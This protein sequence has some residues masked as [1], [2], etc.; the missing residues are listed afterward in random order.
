MSLWNLCTSPVV[1]LSPDCRIRRVIDPRR[2]CDFVVL[3][4]NDSVLSVS[5][6]L[7]C[8][9]RG[10]IL[11]F[12]RRSTFFSTCMDLHIDSEGGQL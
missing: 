3:V 10:P 2:E 1:D 9:L 8:C 11:V 5:P 6:T 4:E 7:E 12:Y